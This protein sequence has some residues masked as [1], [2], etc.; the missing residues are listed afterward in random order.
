MLMIKFIWS[1]V[2]LSFVL[3]LTVTIVLARLNWNDEVRGRVYSIVLG[4]TGALL[5]AIL[6]ALKPSSFQ[7]A[8]V[9]PVPFND[10]A[11]GPPLVVGSSNPRWGE[12]AI[13]AKPAILK[14]GK[15]V[16]T[17]STPT[18]L[19]EQFTFC[20]ELI[21]YEVV[22][23][24]RDL[25]KGGRPTISI[26]PKGAEGTLSPGMELPSGVQIPG[27]SYTSEISKNRFSVSSS[28]QFYWK[29]AVFVLP[30]GTK[31]TLDRIPT[32]PGTGAEKFV[33]RLQK[34]MFFTFEVSIGALPSS[35]PGAP[36]ASLELPEGIKQG[37]QTFFYQITTRAQFERLTSGSK[38]AGEYRAWLEWL[39]ARL[40]EQMS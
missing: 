6:S 36:P 1:A 4:G 9:A 22:K 34:Q 23:R 40:Q 18:T 30:P 13:L 20:G 26:T 29:V 39:A 11:G 31:M 24:I 19:G 12:L 32:S 10:A 2:L 28:E 37:T 7:K 21:Q 16:V 27:S 8:F 5:L 25:S 33:V 15:T 14:D 17:V 38:E 35:G 3:L